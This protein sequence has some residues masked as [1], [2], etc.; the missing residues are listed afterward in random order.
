MPSSLVVGSSAPQAGRVVVGYKRTVA[1]H[2]AVAALE[3]NE[4]TEAQVAQG[5]SNKDGFS[6]V[7]PFADF[8]GTLKAIDNDY[9]QEDK[10]RH[11]EAAEIAGQPKPAPEIREAPHTEKGS[12]CSTYG[13]II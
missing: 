6:S 10:E 9:L 7:T 12:A 1:G 5:G 8:R 13:W 11:E 3:R 4:H 2:T